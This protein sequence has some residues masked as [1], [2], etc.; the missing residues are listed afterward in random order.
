MYK[1]AVL[2]AVLFVFQAPAVEPI[3]HGIVFSEEGRF[4]GW[5]ANQGMWS[6][7]NEIVCGFTLGYYKKH[8][9]GGH[10]IDSDKPSVAR[11]ARSLDGGHTWTIEIP[12]YLDENDNERPMT[13]LSEPIEFDNPNLAV[14][15]RGN[16]IFYSTDRAKHWSGPHPLPTFGRPGLLARTDYIVEGKHRLTAFVAAEKEGGSEGQP[17]CI[18]TVDGGLTWEL[19]GWIG[20]QPPASYGYAIMPATVAVPGGAYLSMIRRGGVFDGK[21]RWWLE[22]FLSPDDGARWHLLDQPRIDNAGNPATLTRLSNG[23]IAMTYG[24]RSLPYG[25]RARISS[26]EGQT[27]SEEFILRGDG[28]NWDIGYPRTIQRPD[29]LCVTTYYY[30][31]EGQEERHIAYTLWNP[32][33][34]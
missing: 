3:E 29:G 20:P 32:E 28:A 21:R 18:R 12:G 15:L 23:D 27:W 4:A 25:I 1:C 26:D 8:P 16:R 5:P 31:V 34:E 6:W 14:R 24:W 19:V 33:A 30:H 9:M 17:L 7:D 10:D 11:Q 13:A 22:A 2:V